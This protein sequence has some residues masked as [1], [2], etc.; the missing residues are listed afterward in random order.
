MTAKRYQALLLATLLCSALA[1]ADGF[2]FKDGRLDGES[3]IVLPL[4]PHQIKELKAHF[5]PGYLLRL[6]KFQ[7]TFLLLNSKATRAPTKIQVYKVENLEH[8]CSCGMF[9]LGVLIKPDR[10]ELP[11]FRVCSDQEALDNRIGD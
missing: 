10:I 8:D 9:N 1:R 11:I 2:K 3:V 4:E 6:T 7:R 5:K